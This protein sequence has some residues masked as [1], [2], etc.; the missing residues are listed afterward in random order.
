[1]HKDNITNSV[2]KKRAMLI[3]VL[4]L[5]ISLCFIEYVNSSHANIADNLV[6]E[7]CPNPAIYFCP[8]DNCSQNLAL[9]ITSANNSVHCAFFD[10][11]SSDVINALAKKSIYVDVKLVV[12]N[13]N[14]DNKIRGNVKYD[15][16]RQ[17]THNKFCVIDSMIVWTGSFNPTERG[18]NKNN[19]NAVLIYSKQLAANYEKEF[20]ELWMGRF[21]SGEKTEITK[22]RTNNI[23]IYSYFCPEDSCAEKVIEEIRGARKSVY[24][25][26]F[27]F[28][29]ESI[30]DSLL[31]L[32]DKIEIKGI[33]EKSQGGSKYSQFKRLEEFGIDVRIDSNPYN[34]HHKVFIID[35]N[36]V[37]TGSFNPSKNGDERNDENLLIIKDKDIAE[38]YVDEFFYIWSLTE[39][40]R[41]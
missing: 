22:V 12:D 13:N 11:D 17:L 25:M 9:T 33:F 8:R 28:T 15:T 29:H 3:F 18:S 36:T 14:Q 24:F 26:T 1:M 40:N 31:F 32:D 41:S 7:Q 21:G 10:V 37:I 30:A 39:S 27:S 19:N 38:Q 6:S 4:I 23:T 16:S 5:V 2:S 34:M 20:E 35:N